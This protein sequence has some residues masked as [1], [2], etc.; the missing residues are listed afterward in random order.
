MEAVSVDHLDAISEDEIQLLARSNTVG[1][2]TPAVNLNS[3]S[4]DFAD[5]RN[6]IDQ[7]C[8]VAL[9]TDYNPGSAPCPSQQLVMAISCRYQKLM[10]AEALNAATINAAH[11]IGLGDRVGSIEIG[12]GA[13]LLIMDADDY[14]QIAYELGGNLVSSVFKSGRPLAL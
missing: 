7:G 2:V 11:A 9:S 6:L 14:R 5:A 13:D 3:G 8:V 12:K 10:P 1:V 4:C